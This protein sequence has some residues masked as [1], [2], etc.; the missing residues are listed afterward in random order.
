MNKK[1]K[2]IIALTLIFQL[3]IPVSMLYHHTTVMRFAKNGPEY[4]FKLIDM[5]FWEYDF[6]TGKVD[7]YS[8]PIGI[9][10]GGISYFYDKK[11][12]VTVGE[13]GFADLTETE[14]TYGKSLWVHSDYCRK[15]CTFYE[16]EYSFEPG[17]DI[18]ALMD[19]INKTHGW[20]SNMHENGC[21]AY[22]T[23]KV[24]KGVFIPTAIYVKGEKVITISVE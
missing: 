5:D 23:A 3:I 16:G 22:V 20:A 13:D 17:V 21:Y 10:V 18:R 24:Y 1:L 2:F 11:F 8:D 6:I 15:N 4:K 14:N 9:E 7:S 12:A 19:E